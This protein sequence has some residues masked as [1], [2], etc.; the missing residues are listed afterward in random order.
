MRS[1]DQH[2]YQN[3]L[4]KPDI[5]GIMMLL[6]QMKGDA[7]FHEETQKWRMDGFSSQALEVDLCTYYRCLIILILSMLKLHLSKKKDAKI[8][9][10]HLNLVMLVFIGYSSLTEYS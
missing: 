7:F 2:G 4:V 8:F 5:M 1:H 9:K 10:K 3:G 6:L